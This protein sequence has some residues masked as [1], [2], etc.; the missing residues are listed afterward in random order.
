MSSRGSGGGG[1]QKVHVNLAHAGGGG[2][3]EGRFFEVVLEMIF[4]GW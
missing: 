4:E 3:V 2:C 1:P